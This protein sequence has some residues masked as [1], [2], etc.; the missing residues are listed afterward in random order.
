MTSP[1]SSNQPEVIEIVPPG[2]RVS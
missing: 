2:D 1:P